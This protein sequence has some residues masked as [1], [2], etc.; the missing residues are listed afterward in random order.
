MPGRLLLLL[1]LLLR[2]RRLSGAGEPSANIVGHPGRQQLAPAAD[3]KT[4]SPS[5]HAYKYS[6]PVCLAVPRHLYTSLWCRG[7]STPP[8]TPPPLPSLKYLSYRPTPPTPHLTLPPSS[9]LS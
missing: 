6:G 9:H 5:L 8:S 3:K 4:A 2:R 7:V 1:L